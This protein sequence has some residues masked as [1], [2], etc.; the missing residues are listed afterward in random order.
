ME[1]QKEEDIQGQQRNRNE[2][3]SVEKKT[4]KIHKNLL[5]N[6]DGLNVKINHPTEIKC[7][8]GFNNG[9]NENGTASQG[10]L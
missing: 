5:I 4:T 9:I 10:L 8:F 7:I 2:R 6:Y 1:K 3:E